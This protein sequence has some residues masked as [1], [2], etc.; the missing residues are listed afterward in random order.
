MPSMVPARLNVALS[1]D[2]VMVPET[3]ANGRLVAVDEEDYAE[4]IAEVDVNKP[5]RTVVS[6]KQTD[7]PTV[8]IVDTKGRGCMIMPPSVTGCSQADGT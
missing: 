7:S 6:S 2:H 5:Q 3:D 8:R 4:L 1:T